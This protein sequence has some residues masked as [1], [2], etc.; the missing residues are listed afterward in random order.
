MRRKPRV[1][2]GFLILFGPI[3]HFGESISVQF[4][5]FER[6]YSLQITV[7]G[8]TTLYTLTV[9][10]VADFNKHTHTPGEWAVWSGTVRTWTR[11]VVSRSTTR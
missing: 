1:F 2:A 10:R 7:G 6:G 8:D 3:L 5:I 4:L 9:T 11:A